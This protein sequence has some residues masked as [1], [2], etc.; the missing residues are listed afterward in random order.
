MSSLVILVI[1]LVAWWSVLFSASIYSPGIGDDLQRINNKL[2]LL[3]SSKLLNRLL[4]W[5]FVALFLPLY[6]SVYPLA[7]IVILVL[8]GVFTHWVGLDFI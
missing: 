5:L 8:W 4:K 6:V 3:T 1:G 7:V 2:R